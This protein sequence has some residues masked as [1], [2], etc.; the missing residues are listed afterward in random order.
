M[1][2]DIDRL[3][4]ERVRAAVEQAEERT[5]AEIVPVV[6]PRSADYEVATWRGG[7]AGTLLTL[8]G[9]LLILLVGDGGAIAELASPW[10]L[11]GIVLGGGI[12]TALLTPIAAPLQRVLAGPD[13]LDETVRRRALQA[14]VEEEV[15]ATRDRTGILI[16]V[17]LWERRVEVL[18]DTTVDDRVRPDDWTE[19][20]ARIQ[21][22]LRGGSLT[23]GL[24]E[25]IGMC[26]RLLERR[27]VNVR[28]DD[29]NEL[30]DDVRTPDSPDGGEKSDDEE[31]ED[32]EDT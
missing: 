19:I 28:P 8:S 26:G 18:S 12:A 15:F 22:G 21:D 3:D 32:D 10:V 25:A 24:V 17:S 20:R 29:E 27:G 6:V 16:F 14:F 13:L 31:P 7:A 2:T 4:A 1:L 11:V 30:P 23:D 5:A 9:V